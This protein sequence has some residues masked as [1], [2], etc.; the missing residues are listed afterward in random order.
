MTQQPGIRLTVSGDEVEVLVPPGR[1]PRLPG[2][3]DHAPSGVR[4]CNRDPTVWFESTAPSGVAHLVSENSDASC[5]VTRA[6][7]SYVTLYS[8]E[9]FRC[10]K[11]C[12]TRLEVDVLSR[13]DLTSPWRVNHPAESVR[14][15]SI[16][17]CIRDRHTHTT[18]DSMYIVT[19]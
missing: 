12:V 11:G 16:L 19:S 3:S 1:V 18:P 6:V 15:R 10:R 17:P 8:R 5:L 2:L 4:V 13:N 7:G 9:T 14:N